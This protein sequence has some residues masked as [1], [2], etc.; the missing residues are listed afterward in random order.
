MSYELKQYIV[1]VTSELIHKVWFLTF[2]LMVNNLYYR[3]IDGQPV[4]VN[5]GE[6]SHS[7]TI[8]HRRCDSDVK[9]REEREPP[10]V[11]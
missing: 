9:G 6:V 2:V 7:I 4:Y 5:G 10:P 11:L 3:F 1:L 8:F